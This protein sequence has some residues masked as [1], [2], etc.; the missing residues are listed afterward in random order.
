MTTSL[1][2]TLLKANFIFVVTF[3]ASSC[4][5]PSSSKF[6]AINDSN[7]PFELNVTTTST[8]TTSTTIAQQPDK[9]QT[10]G[11]E[12]LVENINET[13]DL[14]F[15]SNN[16][17]LATRIQIAS[18]ATTSQVLA[19]LVAGP[20]SGDAGLGLRSA[21]SPQLNATIQIAK[22]IATI[23]SSGF[24]LAGLSPVD[25]RL[26][27]AQLVLT[28]TRRPGIGQVLF[29]VNGVQIAVPRGKG[30]LVKPGVPV[31]FDDYFVLLVSE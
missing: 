23:D 27:I 7:I 30:D 19:A 17:V 2:F 4:G 8:T 24:I 20:P 3:V 22:G 1:R 11:S 28:F 14:Y 13:V 25:Q 5:V 6:V 16:R 9:S 18:P 10:D 12:Q 15:I 26:A 31:S 21:L 29:S